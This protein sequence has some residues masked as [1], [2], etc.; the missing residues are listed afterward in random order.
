M[1]KNTFIEFAQDVYKLTLLFPKKE[2]L[3]SKLREIAD[4]MIAEFIMEENNYLG[5]LRHLSE[6]VESYFLIVSQQ[7]WVSSEKIAEIKD[8]CGRIGL[9]LSEI[10]S[11]QEIAGEI[12]VAGEKDKSDAGEG[13]DTC[14]DFVLVPEA[15]PEIAKIKETIETE[16]IFPS[17]K[18]LMEA[19]KPA[20]PMVVSGIPLVSAIAGQNEETDETIA[21]IAEK[22]G[23]ND[24]SNEESGLT[25]G[26]IARQNRIAEFLKEQGRA[27]VWEI[28]KIFPNVSKRTIR[29]DFRSMLK[30]GL[31]E[32]TGERNTTAYKMK[33]NLA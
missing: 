18:D 7:D 22:E 23:E 3:R 5:D 17:P 30:Q 27:Q 20:V 6:L 33:V 4:E 13:F 10:K 16:I 21:A 1:D 8:K 11:S 9:G 19:D 28:Q 31:I 15:A 26:Q 14:L 29:R 32:V 2:P 12:A 24:E 25:A